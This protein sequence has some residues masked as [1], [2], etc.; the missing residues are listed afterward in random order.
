[1]GKD[2]ISLELHIKVKIMP[3]FSAKVKIL[4]R[5]KLSYVKKITRGMFD[6]ATVSGWRVFSRTNASCMV[7]IGGSKNT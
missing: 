1:M 4:K 2:V 7:K 3:P 5:R 6:L